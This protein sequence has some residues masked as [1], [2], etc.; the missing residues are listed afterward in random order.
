[1]YDDEGRYLGRDPDE[2]GLDIVKGGAGFGIPDAFEVAAALYEGRYR[3]ALY[4]ATIF[5]YVHLNWYVAWGL[6]K[7]ITPKYAAG[8]TFHTI[9][10]GKGALAGQ[11]LKHPVML[12]VYAGLSA[13]QQRKT[14]QRIGD[15]STG[16][17]HY[18]RAGDVGSGGSTPVVPS[19]WD[20]NLDFDEL[21]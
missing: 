17:V 9:M 13:H 3:D 7:A 21:F 20:F 10:Q 16:A 15:E 6:V 19:N 2:I 12:P 11:A 4:Y 14:W 8:H 18:S 1:M 5:G